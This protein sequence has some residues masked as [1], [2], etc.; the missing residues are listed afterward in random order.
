MK[1]ALIGLAVASAIS[2]APVYPRAQAPDGQRSVVIQR[3]LV[4]VNGEI[5]TQKDLEERQIEALQDRNKTVK[6]TTDLQTDA[7][8]RALLVEVTP[9]IL[10]NAIDELILVQRARELGNKITE[11]QYKDTI[12]KIKKDNK[13]DKLDDAGFKAAL[14][15]NGMTMDQLRQNIERSWLLQAVQQQEIMSRV[16]MTDEEARQYYDK[17]PDEFMTA[18]AVT[19]R[20]I[21]VTIP[22]TGTGTVKFSVGDDNTARAKITAARE[23]AAKGE[24]FTALVT[25]ISEAPSKAAG[26]IV[27]PINVDELAQS[28][29]DATDKLKVGDVTDVIRTARG[30]QIFKLEARTAQ[31]LA[32]FDQVHEAITQKVYDERRRLETRKFLDRQRGQ[33]LIEWKDEGLKKMYETKMNAT[34]PK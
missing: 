12:E 18:P 17:H 7:S 25:E 27:G 9:D 11:A 23:R 24:D 29:R 5:F 31:Q 22:A 19:M 4:K 2:L 32:P 6:S 34:K 10:S 33:A 28:L 20:E 15:Q 30:Y 14:A 8:L 21:L 16:T 1:H 3:V 13:M 26:G